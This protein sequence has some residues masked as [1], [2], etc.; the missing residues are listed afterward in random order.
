MRKSILALRL[1]GRRAVALFA[2][3]ILLLSAATAG[4]AAEDGRAQTNGFR[5][6][7]LSPF[8]ASAGGS[9]RQFSVLPTGLQN[10]HGVPFRVD[11]RL[12]VTGI[13]CARTGEFFPTEV[14]GIKVGGNAK[15]IH[16]LH[17]TMFADKDGVP[18]AK[19]VFHYGDGS[20]ETVR[21]GYGV[22][23]RAW[24]APRLEKKSELFDRNSQVAWAEADE[25]RGTASRI[26]Q[27]AIEN[28]KPSQAI[29]TID[30]VSL[31]SRAAPFVLAMS[32]EGVESNLPANRSPASRKP[33]RDLRQFGDSVYRG[34]ITVRATDGPSGAPAKN[35]V[36]SLGITDDK[37]T[38]F[39][40]EAHCDAQGV[41]HMPYPPQ[42]A[43]WLSVWVHAPDRAPA[44]I[45]ESKTNR[46]KF[47]G[48]Y[49]V[50]LKPGNTV[51]GLVKD[52]AGKPIAGAQVVIHKISR[53]SPHHY[54]RVDY[55]AVVTGAD[56]QWA[57]HSLPNDLSG[58][59]F[60]VT[61][62][63]Y[64]PAL[65]V[66][67]GFAPPPTNTSSTATIRT[68]SSVSYQRLPDGTLVPMTTRRAVAPRGTTIPL[69][70]SNALLAASAQIILQPAILV[71][72]TA[73]DSKGQPL[74]NTEVI[75]QQT[76][77]VSERK[78]LRTD[79]QGRFR[80]MASAPGDGTLNLLLDGQS[81]TSV[82]VH[83][84][85]TMAP[86]QI[87]LAPPQI[88]H[89]RVADQQQRPVPGARVRVDE[90][91]GT[92][93][94]VRFQTLTDDQGAFVWTGAPPDQI[95]F[96]VTKTNFSSTR[97]SF[98]GTMDNIIIPIT[99]AP[100]IFGKVLDAETKKPIPSFTVI[101]GRK[102][103]QNETQIHW[104]RSESARGLGG[105]YS[106]KI[107]SYYFQPEARVLVEA[108]GYE[109]QVSGPFTGS[110]S[111]LSNFALK[112][113][114]GLAGVVQGPDGTPAAGATLVLVEKG[115]YAYLDMSGNVRVNGGSADAARSDLQG[116]FEFVPKLEPDKVF[117]SHEQGFAE[118][119]VADVTKSG[120]IV[121][122]K[123]G[124]INGAMRVGDKV[125]SDSST[126]RLQ[127]DYQQYV[128]ADG[129]ASGFS[130]SVKA[131]PDSDGNFVF[132]KVPPG[133]HRLAL[134]YRFKDDRDGNPPLSHG[135]LIIVKPGSTAD[136]TLGGTGRQVTGR[137]KILGGEQSDVDW[138]RDVH[139]LMLM[140]PQDAA[141]PRNVRGLT[142]E[143]LVFLG[144]LNVPVAQPVD[145]QAMRERERAQRLY[146]LLFDTNG[147]FHADNVPPGKYNLVLNVTDP[148]D[149]YYNRRM[150]GSLSKEVVVPDEKNAKV[151]AP[152][153]IG[154][155]ELPIRPRVK[156]GKVVPPFEAKTREGKAIKLSDFRG[157]PVLLHFWGLSLGYST[158]D[159]Q[160][161]K[162]FQ[163]TY[164][165]AGQLAII[166]YNLDADANNAEQF[167]K[168]QGMTW[169][170]TYLGQWSQTTVPA[171]FG[172]NGN[173]ACVL[174]DAEGK[175][176]SGQLRGT[177]IRNTVTRLF[178]AELE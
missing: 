43:V 54:G 7:D 85:P 104:D 91:Q 71:A 103:S 98:S 63:E 174:V 127:N 76:T 126:V 155:V 173:S 44:I 152:F 122:Q 163:N 164:A 160:V 176:A 34:E 100:G 10:F 1:R 141:L 140:L 2:G 36:V 49:A 167:A 162:E 144:G 33:L 79:A 107:S 157:K 88:L 129:R 109:P 151:N 93:D 153:D 96:Y 52:A 40:G 4:R 55:D 14:T 92:T 67:D 11:S 62:P 131:D 37:E 116:R 50:T 23:V 171:M 159:M 106:L 102:Y 46:T 58:F 74:T 41:C 95:T 61:H 86:V 80:T 72:G 143:P 48:E 26:F 38:F 101:P 65:Y 154:A 59:S 30:I 73:L 15:R 57:S 18:V 135:S 12:A 81:P 128:N 75:F 32:V 64:R 13:E 118:A 168:R 6:V 124:R 68:S 69:L 17:G 175:V 148:E 110:D 35:A 78:Y 105:E 112:R 9:V 99:R 28:P 84:M 16:L 25:R 77:P 170:Q 66:T 24:I 137:V 82:A 60:Q 115:E 27:T 138:R 97:H 114:K 156:I 123:W 5:F 70:T 146:V 145:F 108:P 90:W 134:E 161:L 178:A 177:A 8:A 53:I 158:Y 142:Q 149:E 94:L 166:G 139:R 51:G 121:L 169:T 3:A 89:G 45:Y 133:E 111:Y 136:V 29:A 20:E 22:H 19:I 130:F 120:K 56:G 113:G 150:I 31:F 119:K 39:F 83:I 42:H 147:N 125:E 132:E 47:S 21:L 87:K 165:S 172:I 117:V